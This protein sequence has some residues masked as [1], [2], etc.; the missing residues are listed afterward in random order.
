MVIRSRKSKKDRQNNGQKKKDRQN[1]G[2]KK[3]DRQNNGQKK[4]GQTKQ[5]PKEEGQTKQWPKE[6]RTDKT[7]AKRRRTD[8]TMAKRKKD[9]K[10]NNDLQNTIQ[11]TKD[12]TT[13]T[14]LRSTYAT[15]QK[16]FSTESCIGTKVAS[17]F[18]DYKKIRL[19]RSL[20]KFIFRYQDLVEIYSVSA[21]KIINDG[22]S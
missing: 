11:K 6:K 17:F 22:F 1:N 2:Q 15:M 3:K 8:K 12:R 7:M 18:K 16:H 14:P 21:E 4:K 19:I 9:R 5:W 13:Q 10:T 20:K